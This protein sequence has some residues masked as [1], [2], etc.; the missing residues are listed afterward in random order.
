MVMKPFRCIRIPQ[1][2]KLVLQANARI[3]EVHIYEYSG[4]QVGAYTPGTGRFVLEGS[5]FPPG[6]Y[7]VRIT[8]AHATATRRIVIA[9]P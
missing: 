1:R 6:V 5:S 7:L 9:N 3:S 2:K 4:R 8:T